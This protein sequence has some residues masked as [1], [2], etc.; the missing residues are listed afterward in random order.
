MSSR[1]PLRQWLPLL[2]YRLVWDEPV[3]PKHVPVPPMPGQ[4]IGVRAGLAMLLA[5]LVLSAFPM[6]S[7]LPKLKSLGVDVGPPY[8]GN[9]YT[10][11]SEASLAVNVALMHGSPAARAQAQR[12]VND[13]NVSLVESLAASILLGSLFLLRRSDRIPR[14]Y[15]GSKPHSDWAT[16]RQLAAAEL[17]SHPVLGHS[18]PGVVLGAIDPPKVF[19]LFPLPPILLVYTGSR[20]VLLSATTRSGKDVGTNTFSQAIWPYAS[21]SNDPKGENYALT[22]GIAAEVYGKIVHRLNFAAGDIGSRFVDVEG[23]VR[24]EQYGSSGWNLFEEIDWGTSLEFTQLFQ[25][26]TL[27][28]I[29]SMKDLEGENG[30]WHRTARVL[31][32]AV[33]YKVWYDPEEPVKSPSRV[34]QLLASGNDEHAQ[35]SL[36]NKASDGP[37]AGIDSIHEMIEGYLGFSASGWTTRPAWIDRVLEGERM[38]N[39]L[40][41]ERKRAEV[42]K[43]VSQSDWERFAAEQ[44]RA[45]KDR[46]ARI[47]REMRHPDMERDLRMIMRIRGDEASSIY[48][49]TNAMLTPWLDPNVIRNSRHSTFTLTGLVNGDRPGALWIV[50]P[51]QYGDMFYPIYRIFYDLALRKYY[52][53]MRHEQESKIPESPWRWPLEWYMNEFASI[54]EIPQLKEAL[55]V[56][57]SYRHRW[58]TMVQ[59][60]RQLSDAYGDKEIITEL[61]GVQVYHTPQDFEVA[62]TLSEALGRR[63]VFVESTNRQGL[64][65]VPTKSIAPDNVPLMDPSQVRAMP[66]EPMFARDREGRELRLADGR[67]L[68]TVQP[69]YQLVLAPNTPPIYSTKV[70]WFSEH[71]AG[72]YRLVRDHHAAAPSRVPIRRDAIVAQAL[73]QRAAGAPAPEPADP[74]ALTVQLGTNVKLVPLSSVAAKA[75]PK[76]EVRQREPVPGERQDGPL[77]DSFRQ[78]SV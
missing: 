18:R 52:P 2:G 20:H 77:P 53:E 45:L 9:V 34:A 15:A 66:T 57:A 23:A 8:F 42:G 56:M 31:A 25:V 41:I 38:R 58:I 61:S 73:E 22:A 54:G 39:E 65:G 37:V 75:P 50:N 16:L 49:T 76:A 70:Q 4:D 29:K 32:K 35:S 67:M 72:I 1:P 14:R 47:E 5:F 21:I 12:M 60:S 63:M 48:S 46:L 10:V 36:G 30:H 40:V 44:R 74:S 17:L 64:W 7:A 27:M 24:E 33:S 78:F 55:P 71:W 51:V 11:L 13:L 26:A 28:V 68:K 43:T 62:K 69:A 59:T 19:G 3:R 6:S